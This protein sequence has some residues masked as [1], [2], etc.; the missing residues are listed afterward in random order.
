MWRRIPNPKDVEIVTADA[1]QPL[2][3]PSEAMSESAIRPTLKSFLQALGTEEQARLILRRLRWPEGVRCPRCR[4]FQVNQVISDDGKARSRILY[5]CVECDYKFSETAG[6]IFQDSHV[7]IRDWLLAIYLMG[8][9]ENGIRVAQLEKF[10]GVNH[11]TAVYMAKRIR[12]E[13]EEYPEFIEDCLQVLPSVNGDMDRATPNKHRHPTLHSVVFK[14]R[15]E[16]L[17]REHMARVRWPNGV[18][19]AKCQKTKVRKVKSTR[20]R[21]RHLYWC[22]GCKRQFSVTSG[23]KEFHGIR[24]FSEWMIALYLMESSP[25]GVPP[26]L[27]ERLLGINYRT[28]VKLIQWFQGKEDRRKQLFEICIGYN[29][30][31]EYEAARQAIKKERQLAKERKANPLTEPHPEVA[32]RKTIAIP[33]RDPFAKPKPTPEEFVFWRRGVDRFES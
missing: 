1:P 10:I 15:T 18:E 2:T 5:Y 7:E 20:G 33:S 21:N 14:F 16:E 17:T 23:T 4:E 26:I 25:R 11:E 6:T 24:N 8:S 29:D 28:A 27:L 30:P 19:C 13:I 3:N 31:A 12:S 9:I 32:R 22:L